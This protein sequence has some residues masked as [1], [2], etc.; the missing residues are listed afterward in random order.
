MTSR[1]QP[2]PEEDD[3]ALAQAV[4]TGSEAAL[5]LLHRRYAPLVFH[6]ACKSLDR[7]AAEE[8]AQDV[9]L[10]VWR[11]AASFDPE[12]GAFRTWLL[13]IAHHR[14]LDE[15]RSRSRQPGR[16]NGLP[17]EGLELSAQD[18]LPDELL[19]REYQR[20]AIESA[21]SALPEVQRKALR[22]AFFAEL[23]H[24]AVADALRVPLGTA[25]ARIRGGLRRLGEHLGALVAGLLLLVLLPWAVVA[26]NRRFK[27]EDRKGRAL[28]LLANSRCQTLRLLP[29]EPGAGS[30]SGLHAS[31]RG[32]PGRGTA[33]LTLS[34]FPAPPE[35]F[36]FTL[37]L[38]AQGRWTAIEVS[39][40]NANGAALQILEIDGLDRAWP[41][42]LRITL[43]GGRAA[44]PTG[45]GI[46]AWKAERKTDPSP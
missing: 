6:I 25:K 11:K 32:I 42:Q 24:G 5:Q 36:R 22:L 14:I 39:P 43:E 10:S 31:F 26:A 17:A 1:I 40:P 19:W 28:D 3:S 44:A 34:H 21:L 37:W 2:L 8:V 7:S 27:E 18:P 45:P 46:A 23:S 9:F 13:S 35:G 30:E 4:A 15:L 20:T 38:E 12:R 33:V 41:E 16:A 29:S